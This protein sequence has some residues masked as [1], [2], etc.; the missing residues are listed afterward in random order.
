MAFK[1]MD[2]KVGGTHPEMTITRTSPV[3]IIVQEGNNLAN[4]DVHPL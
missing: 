4:E 2:A 1:G 3:S